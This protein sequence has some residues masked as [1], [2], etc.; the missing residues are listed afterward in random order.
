M[1]DQAAKKTQ[2]STERFAESLNRT[3]I[4]VMEKLNVV[5]DKFV[6]TSESIEKKGFLGTLQESI[7]SLGRGAKEE[8]SK[9]IEDLR[10][11]KTITGL[12]KDV[13]A[14]KQLGPLPGGEKSVIFNNTINVNGAGD[15]VAV[16]KEVEKLQNETFNNALQNIVP[17]EDR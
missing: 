7:R 3:L 4:P 11:G 6:T 16:A 14:A 12:S 15:P 5:L 17:T 9:R 1:A 10:R 13:R 2:D 8:R